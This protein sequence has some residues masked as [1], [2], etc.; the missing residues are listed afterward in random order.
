MQKTSVQEEDTNVAEIIASLDAMQRTLADLKRRAKRLLLYK[1][2]FAGM[3]DLAMMEDESAVLAE[4]STLEGT[5]KDLQEGKEI[6]TLYTEFQSMKEV[7][8]HGNVKELDMEEIG[9]RVQDF[10]LRTKALL[11]ATRK[12]TVLVQLQQ[13]IADFKEHMH[14][15]LTLANPALEDRHWQEVTA[16][17]HTFSLP[18]GGQSF[19]PALHVQP[20]SRRLP[21]SFMLP[22]P[23]ALCPQHAAPT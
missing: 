4:I 14:V 12:D 2:T 20:F 19:S 23:A 17:P 22:M 10:W 18:T 1:H 16:P 15:V 8:M 7:W 9:P 3:E 13:E 11:K 21:R 5:E 6:W